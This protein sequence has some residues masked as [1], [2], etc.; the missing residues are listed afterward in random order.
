MPSWLLPCT[1]SL[2]NLF[3]KDDED[4][5]KRYRGLIEEKTKIDEQIR[6]LFLNILARAA[7]DR[8][9]QFLRKDPSSFHGKVIDYIVHPKLPFVKYRIE[10]VP[11]LHAM[12]EVPLHLD[13]VKQIRVGDK[14]EFSA[15]T[16]NIGMRFTNFQGV[17][18]ATIELILEPN[19]PIT[20]ER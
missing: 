19:I 20:I 6:T 9:F 3:L 17:Y 15:R 5:S 18:S 11:Y 14:L 2:G 10:L 1:L 13:V 8:G 4:V 12:L 16:F 7:Q